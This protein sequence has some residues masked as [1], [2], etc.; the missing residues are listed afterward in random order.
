MD[1]SSDR[2]PDLNDYK[3]DVGWKGKPSTRAKW[4]SSRNECSSS[5]QKHLTPPTLPE[6]G[7]RPCRDVARW[8]RYE[9]VTKQIPTPR[10][11]FTVNRSATVEKTA[12]QGVPRE[13]V[14]K[15]RC[16]GLCRCHSCECSI[17]T[18]RP[19]QRARNSDT[20]FL[21][22]SID[23]HDVGCKRQRQRCEVEKGD[24]VL[25]R[26]EAGRVLGLEAGD[27]C[28]VE[29]H[30]RSRCQCSRT[31]WFGQRQCLYLSC[32]GQSVPYR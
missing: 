9:T 18:G 30:L 29:G 6:K 13:M 27:T 23:W 7:L 21:D 5:P 16:A 24:E 31:I 14:D 4:R 25:P 17:S 26:A 10:G 3:W 22:R 12:H 15:A 11:T 28:W 20:R 1:S 2:V 19:V 8:D 32:E